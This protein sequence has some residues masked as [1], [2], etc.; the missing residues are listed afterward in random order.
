MEDFQKMY[1]P[2]LQCLGSITSTVGWD[3][4]SVIQ[5]SG[6]L[7][8]TANPTFIDNFHTIKISLVLPTD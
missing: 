3:G 5:A 6:F 7:K 1:E 2:L 8:S 4:N